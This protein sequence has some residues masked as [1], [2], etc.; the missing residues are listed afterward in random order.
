MAAGEECGPVERRAANVHR[1]CVRKARIADEKFNNSPRN[2]PPG[3]ILK[4]LQEYGQILP[5]VIGPFAE[6]DSFLKD[7]AS[8]GAEA[9]WRQMGA[10]SVKDARACYMAYL[11]RSVGICATRQNAVLKERALGICVNTSYKTSAKRRAYSKTSADRWHTHYV[12]HATPGYRTYSNW[13]DE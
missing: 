3:P 1:E 2:G 5:L 12:R 8:F 4:K 7:L 9:T 6:I 10:R 13:R 11:R